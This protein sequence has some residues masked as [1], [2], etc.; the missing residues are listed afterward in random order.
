MAIETNIPTPSQIHAATNLAYAE[1][2]ANYG[3]KIEEVHRLSVCYDMADRMLRGLGAEGFESRHEIH[4]VPG[5]T[6][7]SYISV[8]TGRDE[9]IV[10]PTW[11]QF[12][13]SPR[14]DMPRVLMGSRR[15]VASQ[16]AA[17]GVPNEYLGMWQDVDS[18]M[19]V[20]EQ[21][22]RDAA[23]AW[24]ADEADARGGWKAFTREPAHRHRVQ[25]GGYKG[26][27]RA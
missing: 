2:A 6:E 14:D 13:Q 24:A 10:D 25:K 12:L 4:I 15:Q 26:K 11:Q 19:T 21:R 9:V 20:Q 23:A 7:H 5:R 8:G 3:T 1:V 18:G 27:H 22:T 17:F 16:A